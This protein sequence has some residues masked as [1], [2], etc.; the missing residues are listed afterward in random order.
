MQKI[1]SQKATKNS[2]NFTVEYYKD[3]LDKLI[4][5]SERIIEYKDKQLKKKDKQIH[6][7]DKKIKSKAERIKLLEERIKY[8]L[9][10][11]YIASSEKFRIKQNDKNET[12]DEEETSSESNGLDQANA[13]KNN[14][15]KENSSAVQPKRIRGNRKPLPSYL[16]RVE[17]EHKLSEEELIGPNGEKYE[18]IGE[19]I[20]EQ[21]EVIP[22]QLFVIKNIRFKYAVKGREELGIK[23]AEIHNQ[24]I[25]KSIATSGLLAHIAQS[26]YCNHLPLYRQSQ[27]WSELDI[28]LPRSTLSRWMLQ[29][30]EQSQELIDYMMEEI[31]SYGYI[32][33]DET[34]VTVL[35]RKIK[36]S[37][38]CKHKGYMWLYTNKKGVVY[39]YAT[40]RGKEHPK[41]MLENFTGYIQT[42]AYAGYD[43]I[44]SDD[45]KLVGC[46]AHARRYFADIK[47]ASGKNKK[48]PRIDYILKEISKLYKLEKNAKENKLSENEI[49]K[50]R[51][52][53]SIPILKILHDYLEKINPRVPPKSLFGKA[54]N[55]SLNNWLKLTRYVDDGKLNIDNNSAERKIKPFVIGRKNWLFCGNIRG[56]RASANIYSLIESAKLYN[57]KIFDYLK[58]VF[59]NLPLADTPKKLEQLLPQYA[60]SHLPKNIIKK[61]N[62]LI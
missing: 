60:Q 21:L 39:D 31:K 55:Y 56:A 48:V 23:T 19:I 43:N 27:I 37:E 46:F 45:I 38:K 7:K 1:L 10:C 4:K 57:L 53:E 17:V 35:E 41:R 40:S 44:A 18:K 42:D 11:R 51:Q 62:R 13:I 52:K 22:A 26:K 61:N 9:A 5:N 28:D 3:L 54:I 12:F 2:D 59:E 25:P 49:Y 16:K 15:K 34:P 47:K 33:A 8:L 6:V 58:Y 50:L 14:N 30:G 32:N 24:A 29:I 20:S 36:E